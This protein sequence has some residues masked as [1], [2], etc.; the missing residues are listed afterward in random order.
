[1]VLILWPIKS[2]VDNAKTNFDVIDAFEDDCAYN[3]E[4]KQCKPATQNLCNCFSIPS[5]RRNG[6]TAPD[7]S[8]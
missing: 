6:T 2:Y 3:L 1:M 8:P 4:Q 7:R 5:V